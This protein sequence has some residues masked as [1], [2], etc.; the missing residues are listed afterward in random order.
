MNISALIPAAGIGNRF[1]KTQNKL[2]IEI[3][4]KSILEHSVFAFDSVLSISEIIIVTN[5]EA[6]PIIENLF[7][8]KLR[9]NLKIVLGGKE[10]QDSVRNGLDAVTGDYVLIHDGARPCISKEIIE[11]TINE[12]K[13]NDA[14]VVCVPTIDTIKVCKDDYVVNTPKRSDLYLVQTPQGFKTSLIRDLHKKAIGVDYNFTDDASIC[15]WAKVPVKVVMGDYKNIKVTTQNDIN[16]LKVYFGENMQRIGQGYDV[17]QL[18]KG[19]KLILGGVDIPYEFGLLGHSDADVLL[20]AITDALLGALAL[21]DLG[22]HFPPSDDKY[23]NIDSMI[24]LNKVYDLVKEKNYTISNIDATVIAQKP[25]LSPYIEQMK[26]NIAKN[27]DLDIDCVSVKATTT[28]KLGFEGR[29]EGISAQAVVLVN[30][31]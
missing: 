17:H 22:K 21:G 26:E 11:N 12:L 7:K 8:G 4:G 31:L 29:M 1:S 10:R 5:K 19:R 24:L 2:L 15:E 25:K 9:S 18:V 16:L 14:A 13:D 6:F 27:L 20:H 3:K 28:E 30:K 23:K